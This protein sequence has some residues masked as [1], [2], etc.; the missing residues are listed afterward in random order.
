MGALAIESATAQRNIVIKLPQSS[1]SM[2]SEPQEIPNHNSELLGAAYR[3]SD[4]AMTCALCHSEMEWEECQALGCEDGYYD[5]Y[6]DDPNFYDPGD[7]KRC[8]ECNGKGG[9]WWCPKF[10]CPTKMATRILKSPPVQKL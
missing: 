2:N 1:N 6:E 8:P 7:M 5:A 3:A 10:D 9:E 4:G